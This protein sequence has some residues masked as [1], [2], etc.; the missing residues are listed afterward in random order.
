MDIVRYTQLCQNDIINFLKS[1]H[2]EIDKKLEFDNKD[3]DLISFEHNYGQKNTGFWC[4]VDNN[5][6]IGTVGIRSLSSI[7]DSCAEIRRLY[8]DCD[9]QNQG[10][11]SQ[12]LDYAIEFARKHGYKK[13]R[14]TTS[15]DR[16]T[17]IYM[18]QKRGFYQIQKYR[19][20]FADLFYETTLEHKYYN[21]YKNLITALKEGEQSFRDSLIL[22]PVENVPSSEVLEP[23]STFLHGLYNSDST[24]LTHEKLDTKIQ[25][26]GRDMITQNV[27]TIYRKWAELLEGEAVSMR[28]LSGLHAHM[29]V[30]MGLTSIGD[31]VVILPEVAGGHMSTKAILERLGLVVKELVVDYS[32]QK[33]DIN[34]SL[35]M[36]ESFSPK[37]IFVD[38][39][40]GLIYEDF[41][42]LRETSA[43]KIFDASQYLTNII[44]KDYP[45]PFQWGFDMILSTLHKNLPGPQR[46]LIC[47]KS[48]NEIWNRLRSNI[49]TYV[50]N[51]HVFSI[52]SAGILLNDFEFLR[53]LSKNMLVNTIMLE[54]ELI[55]NGINTV[56]ERNI[57][58]DLPTHHLWIRAK[59]KEE[60]FQWYLDLERLGL[61]VNYRK[62]PYELGYG[63]RLGLSAA[64]NCGLCKGDISE[65]A[66]IITT[67]IQQGYSEEL[68]TH[69]TD[70]I[71]RVTRKYYGK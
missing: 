19:T 56:Q 41:S 3:S 34:A 13:L 49:S 62:L 17:V 30:F 9:Y 53:A 39:S 54:Q 36:I 44:C 8:I 46:A 40:E 58:P 68:K 20:S 26:G 43:Y 37:V 35:K 22:N 29:V 52:Y 48:K 16:T 25:F 33:V 6:I 15:F 60:A 5:K 12:M 10:L 24:R 70:F 61:L 63:L 45:N 66:H 51:M 42:W 50:S 31:H 28:L 7:E 55:K 38:R 2:E 21:L 14:T 47:V 4:L 69:C 64:T 32:Q 71:H 11:G 27:N 1:S 23:C 57:A 59:S 18:L 65:L 67:V